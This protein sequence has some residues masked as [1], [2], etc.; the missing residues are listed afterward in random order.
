MIDR[1]VTY[2][3]GAAGLALATA[4]FFTHGALQAQK[5]KYSELETTVETE[6]KV[7]AQAYAEGL[8]KLRTE[9]DAVNDKYQ[10]AL[11]ESRIREASA[12]SAAAAARTES[13]GLRAQALS[14]AHRIADLATPD[15][16]IREYAT[17]ANG[18]LDQCQRDYQDMAGKAQGHANDVRTLLDAWPWPVNP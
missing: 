17:V 12:R 2:I 10:G 18:L 16:T 11:N 8:D 7:A 9:Q 15:A 3:A 14:A 1:V 6:R 4:L 5:L 13:D